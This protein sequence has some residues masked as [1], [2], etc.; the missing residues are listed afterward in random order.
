MVLGE[1]DQGRCRS[2]TALQLDP[3]LFEAHRDLGVVLALRGDRE[4]AIAALRAALRIRPDD[5][6]VKANLALLTGR[7]GGGDPERRTYRRPG[8][9]DMAPDPDSRSLTTSPEIARGISCSRR[10][11]DEVIGESRPAVRFDTC[12]GETAKRP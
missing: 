7:P 5:P 1:Y 2:A 12:T 8:P 9:L 3:D 11:L 10:S 4:E 6:Q